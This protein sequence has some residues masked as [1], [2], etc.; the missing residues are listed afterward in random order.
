[1]EHILNYFSVTDHDTS[2]DLEHADGLNSLHFRFT[3]MST[4]ML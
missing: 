3:A 1:M 2:K 4:R